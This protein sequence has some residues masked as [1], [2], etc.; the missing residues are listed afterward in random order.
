MGYARSR[1]DSPNEMLGMSVFIEFSAAPWTVSG[2]REQTR[3]R[4]AKAATRADARE[5]VVQE[6][7]ERDRGH[8]YVEHFG[9]LRQR[10]SE[11]N[12]EEC[13]AGDQHEMPLFLELVGS[14]PGKNP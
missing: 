3:T 1:D 2:A 6:R 11:G 7:D 14:A 5:S 8:S 13:G 4:N 10:V 9:S 12:E